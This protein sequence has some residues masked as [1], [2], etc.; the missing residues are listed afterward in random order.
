[1][2]RLSREPALIIVGGIGPGVALL[3]SFF[4]TLP[5]PVETGINA[6][7]VAVAGLL[8]AVI[9]ADEKAVPA[10]MG[11]VQALIVLGLALGLHLD[12]TQQ[13]GIMTVVGIMLAAFVRT[14]VSAPVDARG[15][16]R[17]AA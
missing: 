3:V 16:R 7:A 9:V 6:V 15:A 13:A 5:D 2:L 4:A 10:F 8:T 1:M 17:A 12:S 11:F 14:Q